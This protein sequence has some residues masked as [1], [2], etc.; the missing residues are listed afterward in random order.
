MIEMPG[1]LVGVNTNVPNRLTREAVIHGVI[2]S[3]AGYASVRTEV[4][5]GANSRIDLLLEDDRVPPCYVE[6]KNCT[7]VEDRI[8]YFPDAVTA[9]GLKHL[10]ELA[11]QVRLGRRG[12]MFFLIQR[13]DA[14]LFRP[15]DHIDPAYGRALREVSENGVEILVYDVR[16]SLGHIALGRKIPFEL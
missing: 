4:K 5:Y 13:M 3:L 11:E 2:P 10:M 12:V 7:L 9:R 15:A 16:I 1:S 8:G 6:V 14:D